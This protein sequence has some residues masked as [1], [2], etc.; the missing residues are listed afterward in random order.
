M[1]RMYEFGFVIFLVL[2][3]YCV[4]DCLQSDEGQIRNLPKIAWL[5]LILLFTPI[6]AIAWLAAGRPLGYARPASAYERQVPHYPEYDRPG[7]AAA[8]SPELDEEFLKQ[9]RARA[10]KQRRELEEEQRRR[11]REEGKA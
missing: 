5:L 8:T 9:V 3:I 10:E 11:R 6:G 1:L 7:R 2:D 4:I